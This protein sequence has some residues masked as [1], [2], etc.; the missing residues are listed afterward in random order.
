MATGQ[1]DMKQEKK[2]VDAGVSSFVAKPFN[3]DELATKIEEAFGIL[4]EEEVV[5]TAEERESS[6]AASGKITLRVAH[7]QITDHL[8]LGVLKHLLEKGEFKAETFELETRCMPGWNPVRDAL[9][10]GT[11]DAAC[12]SRPHCHGSLRVRRTGQARPPGPQEREH[13]RP[14]PDR[15]LPRPL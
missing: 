7:I 14:E 12:N 1:G 5:P 4:Q 10:K 8:I 15:P 11:V 9:R 13:L 6:R 2:A 3:K